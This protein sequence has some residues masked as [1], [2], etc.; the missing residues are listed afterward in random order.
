MLLVDV[1]TPAE[2]A[3]GHVPGARNVPLDELEGRIAELGSGESEV[4][5]ICQSGG[6]SARASATLAQ[7]GLRPVN[8]AGGTGAWSAAGY[9]TESAAP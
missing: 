8:I 7:R 3:G 4:Y 2:Y 6:R 1:R 9:A 5:V